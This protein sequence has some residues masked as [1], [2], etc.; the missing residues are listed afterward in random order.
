MSEEGGPVLC[1]SARTTTAVADAVCRAEQPFLGAA[2]ALAASD[3]AAPE[4]AARERETRGSETSFRPS[5]RPTLVADGVGLGAALHR[6]TFFSS[7][8]RQL[9][10][11]QDA[12]GQCCS[13]CHGLPTQVETVG[14][15]TCCCVARTLSLTLLP[16]EKI[17]R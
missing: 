7:T 8:Y 6:T 3:A 4:Q 11:L 16:K 17:R 13:L 15:A 9:A 12:I 5:E 1:R 2:C 14:A 10:A